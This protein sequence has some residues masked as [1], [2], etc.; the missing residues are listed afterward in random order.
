M[1]LMRRPDISDGRIV[2]SYQNDLWIVPEEGGEA[3]RL[4]VHLGME[5]YLSLIHI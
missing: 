5:N 3:R 2:F 1:R 4:T